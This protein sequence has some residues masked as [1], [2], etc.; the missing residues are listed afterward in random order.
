M[1]S[2]LLICFILLFN[3]KGHFLTTAQVS[4]TATIVATKVETQQTLAVKIYPNPVTN[5][6][7]LS[8][9]ETTLLKNIELYNLLGRLIEKFPVQ[10]PTS[11]TLAM[12]EFPAGLYL[13]KLNG[14]HQSK[15]L[16]IKKV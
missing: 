15:T 8:Y 11:T 7:T 13:L 12:G 16:R 1:K 4:K 3:I 14:E 2:I 6:I 10:S 9:Q 5:E